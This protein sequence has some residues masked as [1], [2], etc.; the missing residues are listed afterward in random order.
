MPVTECRARAARVLKERMDV[1]MGIEAFTL[2]SAFSITFRHQ[3]ILDDYLHGARS[4]Y[5]EPGRGAPDTSRTSIAAAVEDH[6]TTLG[7]PWEYETAAADALFV[8]HTDFGSITILPADGGLAARWVWGVQLAQGP[9]S[10]RF[11][12]ELL[13]YQAYASAGAKY[14]LH[15]DDFRGP[16]T[17]A[18]SAP[19]ATAGITV[20]DVNDTLLGVV[21]LAARI[22]EPMYPSTPLAADQYLIPAPLGNAVPDAR[23]SVLPPAAIPGMQLFARWV[24]AIG[25]GRTLGDALNVLGQTQLPPD[26][27][28]AVRT[29]Q[30][31][32]L[33]RLSG[34]PTTAA[35][36]DAFEALLA[37]AGGERVIRIL[38]ARLAFQPQTLDELATVFGVTR[39]RIRQLQKAAEDELTAAAATPGFEEVAWRAVELRQRLGASIPLDCE[40][41]ATHLRRLAQG[42]PEGQRD[43]ARALLFW[44]A[45]PYR[46]DKST[47]W[48]HA[49]GARDAGPPATEDFLRALADTDGRIDSG[50]LDSALLD[51][52][53]VQAAREAWLTEEPHIRRVAGS[54]FH[55]RGT[56]VDKAETVLLALGEPRT[57]DDINDL[58][59]EGH[60]VRGMRGRLLSDDRFMRTDRVRVGLR[61]WGLEEYTGIVDEIGEEIDAR[62]GEASI[63]EVIATVAERFGLRLASVE[64]YSS[65]PRFIIS[66]GLIRRR[67]ADEPYLP[68][69]SVVD[70]P[71]CYVLDENQC[72]FRVRIEKELLRGSGRP[73]PQGLGAWL[74]VLPGQKRVFRNDHADDVLVSWPDSALMGPSLGS[75]RGAVLAGGGAD[76]DHA[77]LTFDR[78]SA[79]LRVSVVDS[80]DLESAS[81]WSRI[82]MLTGVQAEYPS[83]GEVRLAAAVGAPDPGRLRARLR[84][85]GDTDLLQLL[86][87]APDPALDE[88]LDRLREIL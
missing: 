28:E 41:V 58:I 10:D 21:G 6:L 43:I 4:Y 70:E 61:R 36:R 78:V 59:A 55:W 52:G 87:A 20:E 57:A 19:I 86:D 46:Y 38:R 13:E 51:L 76:G 62:G 44:L 73:L 34:K 42:L 84:L 68:R 66:G 30:D 11:C 2:G 25:L 75:V 16:L 17:V 31:V 50:V 45:G 81:G 33:T 12:R 7:V 29:F 63:S 48:I 40:H 5:G 64:S 32:P 85:R 26:V 88:A 27:A 39:E 80:H 82:A 74:G 60:N 35:F 37:R 77:L 22:A 56:V 1:W 53:F 8:A 15:A 72:T 47:G 24:S 3:P 71:A 79:A 18:V 83:A 9:D 49:G 67:S 23:S 65:V 14:E 54:L 69:R